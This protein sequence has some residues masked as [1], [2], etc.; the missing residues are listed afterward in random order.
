ML[1]IYYLD[2][3]AKRASPEQLESLRGRRIWVDATALTPDE[4][5]LISRFFGLHPVTEEDLVSPHT[6]IKVEEFPE[7]IFSAFYGIMRNK[8]VEHV[9]LDFVLG[10]D[11]FISNH[12]KDIRSASELKSNPARLDSLLAKGCDFV[13]HKILDEEIDNF[14]PVLEQIDEHID[15]IET[16]VTKNPKP[17][18][19]TKVLRHKRLI[20]QIKKTAFNQR[21]KIGQLAKSESRFITAAAVPYF[22]DVYDHSIRVS[23]V[24]DSCREAISN[25][26]DA[27]M[28]AV[29]NRM[30]EVMKVLS[31]I[32][33]IALPLTVVSGIYGTNFEILPA[34]AWPHGFWVMVGIMAAIC[35]AM[36]AY[37][38]KHGWI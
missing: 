35:V 8:A 15:H 5:S 31:I 14:F 9:E 27:Y 4:A 29:S 1:D 24:L 6:R 36:L 21:E 38:R 12:K 30:G 28:S 10:Q 3:V 7:Y 16:L 33:T 37:F 26:F 32:A 20:S 25:T 17:E 11:F 13:F 2:G 22:R 18:L 23:D 19:L 34:S